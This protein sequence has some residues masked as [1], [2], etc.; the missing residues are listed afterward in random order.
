M[1]KKN[2]KILHVYSEGPLCLVGLIPKYVSDCSLSMQYAECEMY[3][4][5]AQTQEHCV[6]PKTQ[7][8]AKQIL[9][10]LLEANVDQIFDLFYLFRKERKKSIPQAIVFLGAH[11]LTG[12]Q[13]QQRIKIIGRYGHPQY[14]EK[15]MEND[16]MLLKVLLN[17]M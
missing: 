11:S 15:T 16:I 7:E 13:Q 1:D 10:H 6:K 5:T 8:S 3:C 2:S 9:M 12:K 4:M 14:N 17:G